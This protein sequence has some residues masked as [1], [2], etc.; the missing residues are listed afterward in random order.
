M[1]VTIWQLQLKI[2]VWP[3]IV[4]F[5]KTTL[6][7]SRFTQTDETI[8]KSERDKKFDELIYLLKDKEFSS[9]LIKTKPR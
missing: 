3:Y 1:V 9:L 4:I 7:L 8:I 2:C 5:S 6:N